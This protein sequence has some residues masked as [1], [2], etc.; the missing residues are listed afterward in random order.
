MLL[1]YK[2]RAFS[3]IFLRG[4]KKAAR[5]GNAEAAGA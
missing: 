5:P 2:A 4:G 3:S 1:Y